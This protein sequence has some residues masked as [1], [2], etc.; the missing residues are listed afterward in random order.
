MAKTRFIHTEH[1]NIKHLMR[2]ESLTALEVIERNLMPMALPEQ[3]QKQLE[4]DGYISYTL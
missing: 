1:R 4:D 2:R 3:D